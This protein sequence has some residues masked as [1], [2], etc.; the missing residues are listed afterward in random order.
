MWFEMNQIVNFV[1][2]GNKSIY[3]IQEVTLLILVDCSVKK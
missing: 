2:V 3:V 1:K